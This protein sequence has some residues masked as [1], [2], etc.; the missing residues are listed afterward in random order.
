[1]QYQ[2]MSVFSGVDVKSF[3]FFLVYANRMPVFIML[4]FQAAEVLLTIY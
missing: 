3:S 1:L 2:D 4:E